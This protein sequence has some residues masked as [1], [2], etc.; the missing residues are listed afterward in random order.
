MELRHLRSFCVLAEEEHFSRA[1]RRL[2]LAQPSLTA[3]IKQLEASLGARLFERNS[4]GVALTEAGHLLWERA[5][6]VLLEADNAARALQELGELKRGKVTAGVVQTV[7]A[8]LAPKIVADF[9][10]Q[11]PGV[12]VELRELSADEIETELEAGRLDLGVSFGP[13]RRAGLAWEPLFEEELVAV[14]G[15]S[16]PW[17]RRRFARF[18]EFAQER[19]VLLPAGYCTRRLFDEAAMAAG[20]ACDVVCEMNSIEG[21]LLVL[22]EIGAVSFLPKLVSR[23]ASAQES[24]VCVPL[25]EPNLRRQVALLYP[26]RRYQ[27]KLAAAF[28]EAWKAAR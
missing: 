24:C 20:M 18:S 15:K 14:A 4:R 19:L 12:A 2:N 5:E 25:R 22:P 9:L 1:S 11:R 10:N 23:I 16:H 26:R 21:I 3:Q 6:R 13:P 17:A 28:A 7:K 27:S 8:C